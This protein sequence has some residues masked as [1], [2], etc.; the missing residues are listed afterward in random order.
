[1]KFSLVITLFLL[2]ITA[3]S[4]G[5]LNFYINDLQISFPANTLT[6]IDSSQDRSISNF[7]KSKNQFTPAI[8][9]KLSNLNG[10][11]WIL[12]PLANEYNTNNNYLVITNPHINHIRAWWLDQNFS[13]VKEQQPTGDH[14]AFQTREVIGLNYV[15]SKPLETCRYV[16][17]LI[18]K[19]K[20]I[21]TANIHLANMT[22]LEKRLTQE[23]IL[24]GWLIGI[25]AVICI[26]SMALFIFI[27]EKVYLTYFFFLIF[28]LIYSV[29]D[30]GFANWL[31]A[32]SSGKNIDF[33]R[34]ISLILGM[35]FYISF[36]EQILETKKTL[37]D[38]KKSLA[39]NAFCIHRDVPCFL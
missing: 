10:Q 38:I 20:E 24:F 34:P 2:T 1:M 23:T 32:Y 17:I 33:I 18:D 5:E 13:V 30:F 39:N 11:L 26:V 22:F 12:M 19:R 8:P 9:S 35:I 36:I 31:I 7:Y 27:K 15:F 37:Q 28:M 21:L 4:Q 3:N 16:L 6:W 14:Y 25:V 29:S